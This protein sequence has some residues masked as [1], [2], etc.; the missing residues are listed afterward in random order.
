MPNTCVRSFSPAGGYTPGS[1]TTVTLVCTLDVGTTST[2]IVEELYPAGWTVS[3]ISVGGSDNGTTIRWF[4]L[5]QTLTTPR[6]FTYDIT[7]PLLTTGT[8][9]F[10]GTIDS[11]GPGGFQSAAIGGA[12]SYDELVALAHP[13]DTT[14]GGLGGDENF[15][16][17]TPEILAYAAAFLADDATK[18]PGVT[19]NRTAYVLRG[20]AIFLANAQSR[21]EDVG[22]AAPVDDPTHPARW[23]ELPDI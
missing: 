2:Y 21:Y 11:D 18:F 7:P 3:A 8:A 17:S 9:S 23:Q 13:A 15:R 6:T 19:A 1:P 5:E 22:T 10:S 16:I 4:I 14:V 12:T 20:A